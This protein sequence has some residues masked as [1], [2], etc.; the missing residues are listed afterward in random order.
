MTVTLIAAVARNGVIGADGGIPWHLPEDFAHFKA[1]TLGHTLVMGRATYE[2][3]GRPLPGRTTIVVT[4]DPAWSADGVLV[5]HSLEEALAIAGD[6]EVF[7][8]GGAS[9]YEAALPH[10]DA[11]LLSEVDVE[12]D[13]DTFYPPVDTDVWAEV[14]REPREGFTVVRWER[15]AG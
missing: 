14:S 2:S 15:L 11:Q 13:G 12:P 7:V 5:A 4:R 3:I 9:V 6:D 10:A 1:T 8:A